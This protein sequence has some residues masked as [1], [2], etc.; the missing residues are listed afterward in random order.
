M[1][2]FVYRSALQMPGEGPFVYRSDIQN[3]T[4]LRGMAPIGV[5]WHATMKNGRVKPDGDC[6]VG[7]FALTHAWVDG[8]W[9]EV[10]Q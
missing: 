10:T 9:H 8:K 1:T 4:A 3:G 5:P 7:E 2:K 6:P